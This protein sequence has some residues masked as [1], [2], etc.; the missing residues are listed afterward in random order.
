MNKR[1]SYPSEECFQLDFELGRVSLV[2]LQS[3]RECVV[4]QSVHVVAL[5]Y[6]RQ[7]HRVL[8]LLTVVRLAFHT[9]DKRHIHRL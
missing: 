6:N 3:T 7:T 9:A 8:H 1:L 2:T 4:E 5:S